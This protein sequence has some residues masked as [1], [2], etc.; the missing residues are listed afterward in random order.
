V[1]EAEKSRESETRWQTITRHS[2]KK[3][4]E[5]S[6]DKESNNT[7]LK[8]RADGTASRRT[9]LQCFDNPIAEETRL[10]TFFV[11]EKDDVNPPSAPLSIRNNIH[12]FNTT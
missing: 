2:L 3:K 10:C 4:W 5:H 12:V 1:K 11:N 6:A 9:I 7:H 8:L